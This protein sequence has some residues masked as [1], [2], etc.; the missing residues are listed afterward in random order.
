MDSQLTRQIA[1]ETIY[2]IYGNIKYNHYLSYKC[3][4]LQTMFISRLN[5]NSLYLDNMIN[6]TRITFNKLFSRASLLSSGVS[7]YV[8]HKVA[9]HNDK[10]H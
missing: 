1:V 10:L 5:C 7:Q 9:L 3:N 4:E 2:Y 6:I 8:V